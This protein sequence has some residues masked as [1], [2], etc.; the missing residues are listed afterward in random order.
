MSTDCVLKRDIKYVHKFRLLSHKCMQKKS[1]HASHN[2]KRRL[3]LL[4]IVGDV[5][6]LM[7]WNKN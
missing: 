6:S 3:N 7:H 4:D 2:H 5:V 1:L